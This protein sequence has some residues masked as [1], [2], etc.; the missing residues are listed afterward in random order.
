M[1]VRERERKKLVIYAHLRYIFIYGVID[2][3]SSSSYSAFE[4]SFIY[5]ELNWSHAI[6]TIMIPLP[7]R[8]Q[9][10]YFKWDS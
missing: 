5:G 1:S 2:A 4:S 10:I 3:S 7:P 8:D 9:K 6:T